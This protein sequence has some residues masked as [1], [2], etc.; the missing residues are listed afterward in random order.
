MD[1]IGQVLL[2]SIVWHYHYDYYRAMIH[3]NV[4]RCEC[5]WGT[6]QGAV[7]QVCFGWMATVH[8]GRTAWGWG[9][10]LWVLGMAQRRGGGGVPPVPKRGAIFRKVA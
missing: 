8:I 9:D 6:C 3:H 4:G 10:G 5:K 7:M 2:A 1:T